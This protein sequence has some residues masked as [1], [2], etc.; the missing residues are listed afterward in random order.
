M[1]ADGGPKE[2]SDLLKLILNSTDEGIFGVDND[3]RCT[4]I[5]R[6]ALKML[7]YTPKEVIGKIPHELWHHKMIDG[8]PYP[9]EMCGISKALKSGVGSRVDD[10]V[11]WTKKGTPFPVEYSTFPIVEN[12][13]IKGGVVTFKDISE[14]KA[15]EEKSRQ[16][17]QDLALINTLNSAVNKGASLRSITNILY[18]ETSRIF[19]CFSATLYLLS[20]DKN[21]LVMQHKPNRY[22]ELTGIEDIIG[23]KIPEVKIRLKENGL[24]RRILDSGKSRVTNDPESI[25]LMM[26]E[27][28]ENRMLKRLVP[29]VYKA[30]DIQCVITVP[31]ISENTVF[32]LMDVSS[33][34]Q[35]SQSDLERLT[36][37]GEHI[38][39]LFKRKE[40]EE[41]L[42]YLATHDPL[43][44]LSNRRVM[45][46]ALLRAVARAKRGK[47]SV[48]I[49]LDLNNFKKINDI[50][51]HVK[52]DQ[53]LMKVA[54][55]VRDS[56]RSEDMLARVGGDEFAVLI[57]HASLKKAETTVARIGESVRCIDIPAGSERIQIGCSSGIVLIDGQDRP[58]TLLD[59]AD[60]VMY[61]SKQLLSE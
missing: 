38:T 4:F 36:V 41:K 52:G 30:L 32:G 43:T 5:N 23:Q 27:C 13:A 9:P 19:D 39:A 28:T 50:L 54:A 42:F 45:D 47:K 26:A 40:A 6:S 35:F 17:T 22:F 29:A 11:F 10:E 56:L 58:E 16:K 14:R 31:L 18:K 46:E 12:G 61:A 1:R 8:T 7:G 21:Y 20:D 15:I 48:L 2:T 3:N 59:H 60:R 44:N 57:E 34:R 24:Y 55:R 25:R 33:H 37:I 49:Y 51:G 53:V